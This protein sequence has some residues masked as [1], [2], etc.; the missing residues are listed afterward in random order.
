MARF[1]KL[2]LA[3][4]LGLIPLASATA[5][6]PEQEAMLRRDCS[7]DYLRLCSTYDPDSPQVEQCFQAKMREL[8]P[9]CRT[10]IQAVSR[11]GSGRR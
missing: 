8:T 9:A 10:S 3:F 7:G 1:G 5:L 2:P 6:T 4:L 11:Q